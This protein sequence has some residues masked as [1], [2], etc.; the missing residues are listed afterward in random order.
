M[1]VR[2]RSQRLKEELTSSSSGSEPS[3]T[4]SAPRKRTRKP[5]TSKT[6]K[7]GSKSSRNSKIKPSEKEEMEIKSE[8]ITSPTPTSY[9]HE[10]VE[11]YKQNVDEFRDY[12]KNILD[13]PNKVDLPRKHNVSDPSPRIERI[14]IKHQNNQQMEFLIPPKR[15]DEP[16]EIREKIRAALSPHAQPETV[17]FEIPKSKS[18]SPSYPPIYNESTQLWSPNV[19]SYKEEEAEKI[20]RWLIIL[21]FS[22]LTAVFFSYF[23]AEITAFLKSQLTPLGQSLNQGTEWIMNQISSVWSSLLN[24]I[25]GSGS[26]DTIETDGGEMNDIDVGNSESVTR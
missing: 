14:T 18:K 21:I 4:M 19:P 26:S 25:S 11:Q 24:T 17:P 13:S 12:V 15:K 5:S 6:S 3:V 23:Q 20:S 1:P 10:E 8:D 16:I 2:T 9:Q 7:R 22:I